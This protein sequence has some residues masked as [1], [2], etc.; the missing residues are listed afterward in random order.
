MRTTAKWQLTLGLIAVAGFAA[1]G[2]SAVAGSPETNLSFTIH[3]R[4]D[5]GVDP[6]TLQEAEESA[7]GI[8]RNA[9]VLCR[10][11]D[12]PSTSAQIHEVIAD[13]PAVGLSHIRVNLVPRG[14]NMPAGV[15]GLAPGAGPDRMLVQVF[16]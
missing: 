4:N 13:Q 11:V 8:F 15:T 9:G 14:V 3:V 2:Q 7:S 10:W 16:Y 1:A 5:A 12:A 6:Q